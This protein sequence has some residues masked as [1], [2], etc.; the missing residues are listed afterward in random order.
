[1]QDSAVVSK[2]PTYRRHK[3]TGQAV[4]SLNGRDFYLGKHN[5]RSSRREYDR[6]IGEWLAAGRCLPGGQNGTDL[7]VAEL[8]KAYLN[9]AKGYYCKNGE[10]TG[11]LDRVRL[12]VRQL[13]KTY[14][15]TVVKQFGPLA[16]QSIQKQLAGSGRCRCYCNYLIDS[17]KRIFKWGVS[18]ELVPETIYRALAT[19]PGLKRGR[20]TAPESAPVRPVADEIIDAT[21]PHLPKVVADMV[22]IHRLIGARPTEVCIIRPCDVDIATAVWTY[23]PES[24]KT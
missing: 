5:S 15:P 12:A 23:R 19:V 24:H 10:P 21:L 13:R 16:L 22:R 9:F 8:G 4:V 17:M 6:L 2:V 7:T 18:Q 20:T 11:S 1:M 3:P 14:G